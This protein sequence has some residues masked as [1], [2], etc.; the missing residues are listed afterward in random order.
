MYIFL[1]MNK[2]IIIIFIFNESNLSNLL[3]NSVFNEC[4]R[5][6][7]YILDIIAVNFM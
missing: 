5:L 2:S 1:K 3:F 7:S 6:S 4:S